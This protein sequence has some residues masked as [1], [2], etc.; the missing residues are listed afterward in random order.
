[1]FAACTYDEIAMQE[2]RVENQELVVLLFARPSEADILKEF[3]Y[4]HYNS[5]KYCSIYAIGYTNDFEK[6]NDCTY[7]KV[8]TIS[9]SEWYFSTKAFIEFKE[10]L[11]P[12]I[13]WNYSGEAELLVLQNSPGKENSLNFQNY[14]A[15]NISKG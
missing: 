11:Q 12:R 7:Q 3:E 1:M 5:G 14:V 13:H 2:G 4:I 10:K 6:K 15:I 9:G 8:N